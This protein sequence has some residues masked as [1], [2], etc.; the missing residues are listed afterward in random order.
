M[1]PGKL[2]GRLLKGVAIA[3][4][5]YGGYALLTWS[6]YG[7]TRVPQVKSALD[8]AMPEPEVL[9][10]HTTI[11]EAPSSMTFDVLMNSNVLE[12]PIAHVLMDTRAIAMGAIPQHKALPAVKH[13]SRRPVRRLQ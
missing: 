1:K 7:R 5:A 4:T 11:V 9:E 6:R 12:S 10:R 13:D 8:R 3:G 2:L